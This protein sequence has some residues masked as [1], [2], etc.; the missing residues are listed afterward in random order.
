MIKILKYFFQAFFIYLIFLLIKILGL[1]ISRKF[2]SII[3]KKYGSFF[4]STQIINSNLNKVFSKNDEFKKEIINEMWKNYGMTFVEYIFLNDFKKNNNHIKINGLENLKKIISTN[5]PVI[6]ISG[7]FANYELMCMEL[8]RAG[9]KV[10][11]IYRPLN[12]FFINPLM[13][14]LRRKNVC[15]NQIKKGMK[16]IKES[17]N[18]IKKGYSIALMVDQRVSEGEKI[19]FFGYGALTT[20]IPAQ[21]AIKYNCEIV[22]INLMRN[23][24]NT[25]EMTVLDSIKINK[26]LSRERNKNQITLNINKI[27]EQIILKNPGQWIWTHNRWK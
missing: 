9:V 7:H 22:P 21:F 14:H 1:N 10:A 13:E 20:T 4:K 12:N 27:I 23:K 3:F 5:K 6:F 8:T 11:S 26:K 24:D 19:P 15:K 2:F 16:G 17:V 18:Y 25:F